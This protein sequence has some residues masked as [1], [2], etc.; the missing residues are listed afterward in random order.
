M[1]SPGK[2]GKAR[3]EKVLGIQEWEKMTSKNRISW[4]KRASDKELKKTQHK[5]LNF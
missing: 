5:G 2:K 1:A 4:A 3:R